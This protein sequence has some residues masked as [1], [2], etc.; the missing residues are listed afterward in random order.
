MPACLRLTHAC[1]W[2]VQVHLYVTLLNLGESQV[3]DSITVR[4]KKPDAKRAEPTP[5]LTA[6]EEEDFETRLK[7]RCGSP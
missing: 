6:T 3:K 1:T 4:H 2:H 7:L 5:T